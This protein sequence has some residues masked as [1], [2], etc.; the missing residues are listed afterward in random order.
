MAHCAGGDGTSTFDSVTTLEHWV[1][2]KKTPAQIIAS[3]LTSG[4]ADRTRPLCPY[5]TIAAY[6]GTGDTNDAANFSCAK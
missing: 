4:T 1:E 2:Q 5:P 6:K 3:H